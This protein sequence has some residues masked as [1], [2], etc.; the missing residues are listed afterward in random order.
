MYYS[1]TRL[2]SCCCFALRRWARYVCLSVCL[3][4]YISQKP[5]DCLNFKKCSVHVTGL[6]PW[7][8]PPQT[9]VQYALGPSGF[10]DDVMFSHNGADGPK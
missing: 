5:H 9:T 6:W 4:A 2:I 7:L 10:V 8:G 3:S 1:L